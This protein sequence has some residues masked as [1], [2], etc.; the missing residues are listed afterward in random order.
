MKRFVSGLSLGRLLLA[1]CV[2]ALVALGAFS[3][4]HLAVSAAPD[5]AQ[6]LYS[7]S[8]G[9]TA[10]QTARV[11]VT[12]VS[13]KSITVSMALLDDQG[14]VLLQC[15]GVLVGLNETYWMDLDGATFI[16]K[17]PAR[18]QLHAKIWVKTTDTTIFTK[19]LPSIE[20]FETATGQTTL[21]YPLSQP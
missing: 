4:T 10:A 11:S 2:S 9:F 14:K 18:A 5:A 16:S 8:F 21:L 1:A 15:N 7:D 17:A 6:K 13:G 3:F 20:V 12:N 19:L